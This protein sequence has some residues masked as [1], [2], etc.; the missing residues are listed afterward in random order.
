MHRRHLAILISPLLLVPF[1]RLPDAAAS[2]PSPDVASVSADFEATSA[3]SLGLPVTDDVTVEFARADVPAEV[4]VVAVTLP[5]SAADSDVFYRTDTAD[6][7]TK[8][9]ID[10]DAGDD[11]TV[12]S[13][14]IVVTDTHGVQVAS[15]AEGATLTVY[16]SAVTD[17]DADASSLAWDSPRIL[18]R[19]AWGADESI[20]KLPYQRGAVT[21]AMVHHTA[22]SNT[23]T[24]AQVPAILRS[25]QAYHVNGRGWKDIAYNILVD[26]FGR[27]WEGR[28]GGVNQPIAGG[29]AYGV[30]NRRVFGI[31]M[32]GNYET[33]QPSS[34]MIETT[35]QVIAWKL[36]MHGVDP[37]GSTWGSGGQD[38]GSTYLRAISGHRDENATACPGRY[39]YAQLPNVRARVRTL[40]DTVAYPRFRDVPV[41]MMFETDIRW[42]ADRGI[43]TGWADGTYRPLNAISREAMA[44]FL[45]RLAGSPAFTAPA[46]S[47]FRDVATSHT[48][49]KEI[50][51]LA[52]RGITTGYPDGTFRPSGTTTR[53][54]MAAYLYR[55]Y[56][57]RVP[58]GA[59]TTTAFSDVP[60]GSLFG[61][62][63]AWLASAGISTGYPDG[64]FQP[65]AEVR[66]DAMAAFMHRA[67]DRLG[68]P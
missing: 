18:S 17:A 50:T 19:Q 21:G 61:R 62:E 3:T 7:W 64:T 44:A 40:M 25:I 13:D 47:P 24:S 4:G 38:G 53:E 65:T 32:M 60:A 58:A 59:G 36:Q 20:V 14:P 1:V 63:I 29:H 48:F 26:R 11:G 54:A 55:L 27:A 37:Y 56:R 49:Y 28:G 35:S 9:E 23:Y 43:S 67:V 45:Y 22:G 66:R 57:G 68:A 51:W 31:S 33:A 10:A 16:S 41:G 34:A 6:A 8:V 52:S 2:P 30:T 39:M 15:L 5:A 46:T 12:G 42:L